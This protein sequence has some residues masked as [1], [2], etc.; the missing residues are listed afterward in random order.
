M[1]KIYILGPAYPYRGGIAV[2]SEQLARTYLAEGHQLQ[3]HTFKVQYPNFLFPGRTQF[4]TDGIAP[5]LPI[6]RSINS[7]NPINWWRVGNTIKKQRPDVLVWQ[8]W[9]PFMAPCFGTINCLVRKNQHTKVI[10]VI[11][12]AI[13]HEKR[14]FDQSFTRYFLQSCDGFVALSRSVLDDIGQFT[15]NTNKQFIPLPVSDNFGE[16]V[17]KALARKQLNIDPSDKLLL[18]FGLVRHYKGLDIL[19]EAL[20]DP[21]VKEQGIKLLVAGEF[22]EDESKY[23]ELIDNLGIRERLVLHPKFIPNDLVKH[24]FCA[25]DMVVQPYRH[26]TQSGISQMAYQFERP[27]LVTAVGGLPEIVPHNKVGYVLPPMQPQAIADAI[28]NFYENEREATF[29]HA[30]AIEK[31][32]FSWQA[33]GEGILQLAANAG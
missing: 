2:F 9:L 13:P 12:N 22:Y 30:V 1:K 8:Y 32:K 19:L 6:S 16:K 26:A 4:D 21:R 28:I 7:I 31:Q 14:P 25:A 15:D 29:A 17:A 27:M 24:Y 5:N 10:A 33:M 18:F 20:A 23:Q 3:L 11:H